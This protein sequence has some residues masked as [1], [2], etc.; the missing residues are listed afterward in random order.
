MPGASKGRKRKTRAASNSES[1]QD[2]QA[3]VCKPEC[4]YVP[5][6][7]TS[8]RAKLV[9]KK[10][11]GNSNNLNQDIPLTQPT[12]NTL[13]YSE[14]ASQTQSISSTQIPVPLTQPAH[15]P[16]YH[17]LSNEMSDCDDI[18][19]EAESELAPDKHFPATQPVHSANEETNSAI[20]AT[21][22]VCVTDK[23]I[24]NST[25]HVSANQLGYTVESI[26]EMTDEKTA[27]DEH[28]LSAIP[29]QN[30]NKE[31]Q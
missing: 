6:F 10:K 14:D 23:K 20:P 28:I 26:S 25:A 8:K 18:A 9:L 13:A 22:P 19:S 31:V 16:I 7:G 4:K 29:A 30:T 17:T 11:S 3:Q 21:Q 5:R 24:N 1:S 12:P 15:V 2:S 27:L